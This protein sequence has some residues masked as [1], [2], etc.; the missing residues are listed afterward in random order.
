MGKG[1]KRP[2]IE[3]KLAAAAASDGSDG[4]TAAAVA[5]AAKKVEDARQLKAQKTADR[6]AREK[7]FRATNPQRLADEVYG[8]GGGG[9]GGDDGGGRRCDCAQRRPRQGSVHTRERGTRGSRRG[10]RRGGGCGGGSRRGG[11]DGGGGE[12]PGGGTEE[13]WEVRCR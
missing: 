10:V 5:T 6:S 9:D 13:L 7:H 2:W 11:E 3:A 8:E 1:K 12:A 4:G